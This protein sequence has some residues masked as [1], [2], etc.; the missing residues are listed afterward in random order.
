MGIALVLAALS[1]FV[2]LSYEILW[3]RVYTFLSWGRANSFG[4]LLGAYLLGL[5]FGAFL[6]RRFCREDRAGRALAWFLLAANVFGFLVIPLVAEIGRVVP[7][8]FALPV[9]ALA[10]GLLGTGFPLIAHVSIASGDAVGTRVS[11]L[12]VANILGSAA[13]SL[14]TGFVLLDVLSLAAANA[15]IALTGLVM[16]ALAARVAGLGA[17]GAAASA[18][19]AVLVL[20]VTPVAFDGLYE[21]LTFKDE[22]EGQ[23]FVR[24]L[25]IG[26]MLFAAPAVAV[27]QPAD[28]ILHSGRVVTVDEDKVVRGG[29]VYDGKFSVDPVDDVNDIV[30]AYGVF[31][32]HEAPRSV[33][34][35]GL[36]SGSWAQV[37]VHHPTVERLVAVEINRGYLEV[38][39]EE[40]VVK[41]LLDNPKVE[42]VV[43]DGRRWLNRTEETFDVIVQNTT[44]H[45]RAHITNLL[46]REYL[47]LAQ[48]H[49]NEGGVMLYNTTHS[50][51][52]QKT[53]LTVFDRGWLL[54]RAMLVTDAPVRPAFARWRELLARYEVDGERV[55][56][57]D[58]VPD[59]A[60][61]CSPARWTGPAE[62][63][64]QVADA[65]V[66]TDDN[67]A[68]EWPR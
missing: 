3:F 15:S 19:A 39:A 46:S 21:K 33:L 9:V 38:I 58:R 34:V 32:L 52:A 4:T 61:V 49:L 27:A 60:A 25:L 36:G 30:R 68:C 55:V 65:V 67:M 51:D 10:A 7:Y 5:A 23:R 45:W 59:L 14:L 37:L 17:R 26:F 57:P 42:I 62:L 28:L 2:A 8:P 24:V 20:A 13:G 41:S 54:E 31:A 6:A 12:Y 48:R 63:R 47:E 66:I 40:P 29:A 18:G 43:D 56:P 16:T 50:K 53:G 11:W 22:Y 64:K 44:Y 1:G 35:V